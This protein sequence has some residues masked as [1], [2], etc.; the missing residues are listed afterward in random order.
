ME[1]KSVRHIK[2]SKKLGVPR[3][4]KFST[5]SVSRLRHAVSTV[6]PLKTLANVDPSKVTP[7]GFR[8]TLPN[9]EPIEEETLLDYKVTVFY[10]AEIGMTLHNRYVILGKL[11][12]GAYSTVWLCHDTK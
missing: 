2:S 5:A 1:G 8:G 7:P 4:A 3:L 9:D 6:F 10:P 12:Y 11:G